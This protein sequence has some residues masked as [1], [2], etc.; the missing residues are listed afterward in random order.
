[1]SDQA[2]KAT[3]LCDP[4]ERHHWVHQRSVEGPAVWVGK[5]SMCPAVTVD[6]KD[7]DA[8]VEAAER[9]RLREQVKD[10]R[11]EIE[12]EALVIGALAGA[13]LLHQAD[14]VDRVL[15]LLGGGSDG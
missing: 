3:Y 2:V 5:C 11:D 12:G 6:L 13:R 7:H 1:M 4:P 9:E 8:K 10:L 15:D 14:G